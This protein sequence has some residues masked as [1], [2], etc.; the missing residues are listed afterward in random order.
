MPLNDIVY[1]L[2][3]NKNITLWILITFLTLTFLS[4]IARYSDLA[5]YE[6]SELNPHITSSEFYTGRLG[7][8]HTSAG[9]AG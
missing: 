5:L 1:K 9:T 8:Q 6:V 3:G 2:K 4:S 7:F